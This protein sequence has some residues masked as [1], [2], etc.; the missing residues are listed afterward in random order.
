MNPLSEMN[1]GELKEYAKKEFNLTLDMR[2]SV[3]ILRDEVQKHRDK[4]SNH[5]AFGIYADKSLIDYSAKPKP[6]H[7][8]NPATGF[9]WPHSRLLEERGDLVPCDENGNAV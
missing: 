9:F 1:K 6:T 4:Y 3:E 8:K 2:K 7:L 5:G